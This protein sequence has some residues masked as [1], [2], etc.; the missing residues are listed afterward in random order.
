MKPVSSRLGRARGDA[1]GSTLRDLLSKAEQ[2]TASYPFI[3]IFLCLGI[4]N[5]QNLIYFKS[6]ESMIHT[7]L[8]SQIQL[9]SIVT[10]LLCGRVHMV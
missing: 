2:P 9:N 7:F 6:G 8:G 4:I 10:H 3:L 5:L 1:N